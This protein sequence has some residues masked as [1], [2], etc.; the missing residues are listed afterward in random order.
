MKTNFVFY[1]FVTVCQV[2]HALILHLCVGQ[3]E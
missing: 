1:I 2:S 3:L